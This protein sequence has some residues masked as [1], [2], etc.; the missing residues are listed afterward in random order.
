MAS[1]LNSITGTVNVVTGVGSGLGKST[2]QWLLRK[3]S[4][5]VL[6]ID[7]YYEPDFEKDL[8]VSEEERSR[9][10]LKKHQ[11][12]EDDVGASLE[13]FYKTHG[14]IDNLINVAGVAMAFT[15]TSNRGTPYKL[16]NAQTLLDFNTIGTFNMVR[17]ASPFMIDDKKQSENPHR[18]GCIINTSCIS[19]KKPS[20]GQSFY[21]ASK[22][23][24]DS[25]TLSLARDLSRY[26]IRC[27]TINV[28][29]FDTPLLRANSEKMSEWLPQM[30]LCPSRLGHPDEF[31]HLVGSIIE[32]PML[33]GCC[34]HLDGCAEA[35]QDKPPGNLFKRES[36]K[37]QSQ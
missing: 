21:A 16:E 23:A 22:G 30:I 8:N 36:K 5:P 29:Y 2:L 1:L 18:T 25:M 11:T 34:I 6:G 26:N 31:A 19:T 4:G 20:V 3:G 7:R 37:T 35:A 12:F 27:N 32:N 15:M 13:E 14:M 17:L 28:G 9:L 24:I 10:T 33:N